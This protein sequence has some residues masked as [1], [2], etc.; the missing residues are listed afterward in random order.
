MEKIITGY[1]CLQCFV[2][3][4]DKVLKLLNLP[5]NEKIKI[6]L[7]SLKFLSEIK[8]FHCAP[9]EIARQVYEFLYKE[10][11]DNNPFRKLKEKTTFSL[12]GCKK[13]FSGVPEMISISRSFW[14]AQH[15]LNYPLCSQKHIEIEYNSQRP[16][17]PKSCAS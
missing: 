6:Y 10:T 3:Q 11:G 9:P 2:E 7:K 8:D 5:E 15:D 13:R 16:I 1:N 4:I 17:V 14:G 12:G